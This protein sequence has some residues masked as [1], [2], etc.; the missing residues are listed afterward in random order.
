MTYGKSGK[1]T[2]RRGR[3]RKR[4]PQR[5]KLVRIM[6]AAAEVGERRVGPGDNVTRRRRRLLLAFVVII[7][8]IAWGVWR[9]LV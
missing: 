4:D 1:K 3:G 5:E 2:Q 9:E 7:V 8:I 6:Y